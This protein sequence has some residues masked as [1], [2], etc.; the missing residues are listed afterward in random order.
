MGAKSLQNKKELFKTHRYLD[1]VSDSSYR[2]KEKFRPRLCDLLAVILSNSSSLG[3]H[4]NP[5]IALLAMQNGLC[6]RPAESDLWGIM[7]D[8]LTKHCE[9]RANTGWVVGQG[10]L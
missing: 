5:L 7:H 8:C 1:T 2:V 6:C 10:D 3:T 4:Q 9:R